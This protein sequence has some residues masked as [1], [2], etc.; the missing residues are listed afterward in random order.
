MIWDP[1]KTVKKNE[2]IERRM[3]KA[4]GNVNY[5]SGVINVKDNASLMAVME[6]VSTML[7][8]TLF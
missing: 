8:D 4:S 3:R 6:T 5:L 7:L 2:G 1:T